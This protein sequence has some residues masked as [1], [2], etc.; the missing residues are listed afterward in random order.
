MQ[1]NQFTVT[2]RI[3]CQLRQWHVDLATGWIHQTARATTTISDRSA[4]VFSPHQDDETLGCGGLIA[5]KRSCGIPVRVIFLTNGDAYTG[6]HDASL[7]QIRRQ[8]ALAA[9]AILGVVPADVEFWDYPDAQLRQLA[10]P[11]QAVLLQQV[12]RVLA[13]DANAEIYVPHGIDQHDDHE[14][15]YDIVKQAI[16]QMGQTYPLYQYPIWIFWKAP[17]FLKLKPRDLTGWR[18]LNIQAVMPQKQAA[19]AAHASQIPT[20]PTGF[21][22]RFLRPEELFYVGSDVNDGAIDKRGV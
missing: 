4:I 6:N 9:L 20:L 7:A 8:E 21:I 15:T 3:L 5:L 10:A 22:N 12:M 19:I 17:L 11:Q 1:L 14:A 18:R 16:A 13:I 2:R